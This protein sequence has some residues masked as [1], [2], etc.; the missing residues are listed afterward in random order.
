MYDFFAYVQIKHKKKIE[1]VLN[2]AISNNM[3]E[4]KDRK[5]IWYEK[6]VRQK[7]KTKEEDL[8][9]LLEEP[10]KTHLLFYELE[11]G[12]HFSWK[13][14]LTEFYKLSLDDYNKD[15]NKELPEIFTN[16]KI[17]SNVLKKV[18]FKLTL[19]SPFFTASENKFY[20]ISNPIAKERPTG[21]PVLKGS[22]LKGALRQAAVDNIENKLL[23]KNYGDKFKEY[24]N[25]KEDAIIEAEKIKTDRFFFKKRSQLVKLFGNEKDT[26]WFTFKS[27]LATG[28]IKDVEKIKNILEKINNAFEHYLKKEQIVNSEGVCRGRLIFEDLQF[29]KVNLDVITPLDRTKRTP[30]HGPIFY[31]IVP[32]GEIITGKLI[33]F[34][35]DLIAK[36][37]FSKI[38]DEWKTDKEL[39]EKAF[40]KLSKKGIGAKTKAGWGRLNWE[41]INES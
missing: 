25:N 14:V 39:I 34:P 24:L 40:E 31:E 3:V 10:I 11:K 36:G 7:V 30:V 22:S 13:S 19:K 2:D 18:L 20:S 5:A 26:K 21:L 35:F 29:K 23:E 32:E 9:G 16:K 33:W 38:Q 41:E 37:E 8:T 6:H 12:K 4:F 27:L 17:S 1:T 15:L 28:G